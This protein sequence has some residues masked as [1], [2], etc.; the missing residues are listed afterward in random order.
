MRG[1]DP[2]SLDG[3]AAGDHGRVRIAREGRKFG[4]GLVLSSQ[5]P[6]ELSP[7]R[8]SRKSTRWSTSAAPPR[9]QRPI[10]I[11]SIRGRQNIIA[12]NFYRPSKPEAADPADLARFPKIGPITIDQAFGGW[13]KAQAG[14]P[15]RGRA[16]LKK[17]IDDYEKASGNKID[18][19]II[20]FGPLNQ[21]IVS[22]L[23]SGDVPDLP[24]DPAEP[25]DGC[26]LISTLVL[27]AQRV[28]EH[29][30]EKVLCSV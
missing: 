28:V 10:S 19:S 12:P 20:P 14:A 15:C 17:T 21:K 18:H 11:S 7:S 6:S 8:R 4:L 2:Q 5:R 9:W 26:G 3:P 24:V 13:T 23:T 29:P 25:F 22:V 27:V 16:A 1:P 30:F